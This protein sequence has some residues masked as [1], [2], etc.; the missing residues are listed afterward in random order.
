MNPVVTTDGR[1]QSWSAAWYSM[2]HEFDLLPI[3]AK[4]STH[5]R[6]RRLEL[7]QGQVSAEVQD[8]TQG[9]CQ[10]SLAF[11]RLP[12]HV[13]TELVNL[14]FPQ[15]SGTQQIDAQLLF[16]EKEPTF[17]QLSTLLLP[18]TADEIRVHCSCCQ[19]ADQ[20][21]PALH[22]VLYQVG[23]LLDEE[24]VTLLRL[25]GREWQ[26]LLQELQQRRATNYP[27]TVPTGTT[28]P[29][30]PAVDSVIT[31][32]DATE[33]RTDE[34]ALEAQPGIFWGSRR[35]LETFHHHIAP[36]SLA[37]AILRRLGPLP[38]DLN[39]P[40]V[41]Q[42]LAAL[43]HQVTRQAEALAYDLDSEEDASE[44]QVVS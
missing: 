1:D 22:A 29:R 39:D 4:V 5:S 11:A 23:A 41:D 42:Q 14:L 8:R 36:P 7:L 43:Y 9:L 33:T 18:V 31:S 44:N 25:R 35:A 13:W 17:S 16:S 32:S 15:V 19:A 26:T 12:H 6:I 28:R 10:V 40:F 34:H 2:L 30:S 20:H 37:L 38:E 27:S 24:P 21:C 3:D